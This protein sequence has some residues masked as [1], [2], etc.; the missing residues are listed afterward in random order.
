MTTGVLPQG[1]SFGY[2]ALQA[3]Y[4]PAMVVVGSAT[5]AAVAAPLVFLTGFCGT[6]ALTGPQARTVPRPVTRHAAMPILTFL[7]LTDRAD[8]A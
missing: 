3:R 2:L 8:Q 4:P 6:T 1:R 7:R 5:R